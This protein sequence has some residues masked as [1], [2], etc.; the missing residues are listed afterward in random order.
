M[1][2]YVYRNLNTGETFELKQSMSEAALTQHPETGEPVKRLISAPGIAFKG[3]GFYANDSRPVAS[4]G[5]SSSAK[6]PSSTASTPE[7]KPSQPSSESVSSPAASTSKSD[8]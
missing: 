8:G 7:T 5:K 2:T 6:E 3:S 1:P 4:T